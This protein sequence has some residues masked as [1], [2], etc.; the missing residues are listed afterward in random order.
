ME[1]KPVIEKAGGITKLARELGVS[2]ACVHQW[3][4]GQR[5]VPLRQWVRIGARWPALAPLHLVQEMAERGGKH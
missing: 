2:H 5:A 3:V 1:I 4:E